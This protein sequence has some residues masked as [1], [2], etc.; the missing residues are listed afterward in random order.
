MIV[1]K[2][3]SI[4]TVTYNCEDTVEKTLLSII[5]QDYFEKELIVIDG[6][7]T[8]NTI[9]IIE[10]YA[11]ELTMYVGKDSGIY[12]AMNKGISKVNGEWVIFMNSGDL[13]FS[14]SILSDIKHCFTTD[15]YVIAG[16]SLYLYPDKSKIHLPITF[17]IGVMPASHQSIFIRTDIIKKYLFDLSFKV[18][19]DY[20]QLFKIY[21]DFPY[22][23]Y[24]IRNIISIVDGVGYSTMNSDLYLSEYREIIKTNS[25]VISSDLWFYKRLII[26]SLKKILNKIILCL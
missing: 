9:S 7:S 5:R 14:D 21:L 23:F 3:V 8:D 4:I 1:H 26:Q 2:L 6:G 25:S 16:A 11:N 22:T 10:K 20:N 18:S 12:D 13:F 17:R 15:Y 24:Y 19:A